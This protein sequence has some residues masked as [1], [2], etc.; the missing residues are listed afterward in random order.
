M[1]ALQLTEGTISVHI[2]RLQHDGL[3][4]RSPDPHDQRGVLVRLT[5]AGE[6]LFERVAPIH[7]ANEDRLLSALDAEQREQLAALLLSFEGA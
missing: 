1:D 7:L 3:V 4:A 2:D 5:S 6:Q